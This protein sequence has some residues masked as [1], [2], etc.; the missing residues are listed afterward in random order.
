MLAEGRAEIPQIE[1]EP[2]VGDYATAIE[3]LLL[4]QATQP[5]VI[6][7]VLSWATC[8]ARSSR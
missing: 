5:A 6:G 7:R 2:E 1:S 3:P 4:E 8:T